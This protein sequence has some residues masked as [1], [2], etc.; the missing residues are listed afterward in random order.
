M[1]TWQLKLLFDGACPICRREMQWLKRRDRNDKIVLEDISQPGFSPARYGLTTAEVTARLCGILPDGRVVRGVEAIRRAYQIVG[2]GW[3]VA[4]AGWPLVGGLADRLYRLFAH[5]RLRLGRL[6]G[7]R[8]G[9]TA[10]VTAN[11]VPDDKRVIHA[12]GACRSRTED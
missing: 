11:G 6:L 8:A 5:H 4:P 9:R 2:L 10:C 1:P 7:G 3:L 12:G